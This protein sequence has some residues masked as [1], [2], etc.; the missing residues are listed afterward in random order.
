MTE[1]PFEIHV[2]HQGGFRV[3]RLSGH[4]GMGSAEDLGRSLGA[5]AIE[6]SPYIVLDFSDVE[7]WGSRAIGVLLQVRNSLLNSNG[8]LVLGNFSPPIQSAFKVARLN[9]IFVIVQ[10]LDELLRRGEKIIGGKK[11]SGHF[12]E[13]R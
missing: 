5:L 10:D 8:R 9:E 4:F 6:E 12:E 7:F 11:A 2:G 3:V 1:K 13:D